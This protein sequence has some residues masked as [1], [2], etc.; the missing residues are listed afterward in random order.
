MLIYHCI[1]GMII[2]PAH[3]SLPSNL[4][5][6]SSMYILYIYYIQGS[7]KESVR[8]SF[9]NIR[10]DHSTSDTPKRVTKAGAS[11]Q[12]PS[13]RLRANATEI[14]MSEEDYKEAVSEIKGEWKKGKNHARL[15]NLME[16][17]FATRRKWI[18]EEHPLVTE[19]F[20]CLSSTKE[21]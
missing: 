15:K 2:P 9:K 18:A 12:P 6:Q 11:L 1:L 7:W 20:P 13:K 14:D 21:K 16:T 3:I 5:N 10:R 17:T 19:N 4:I 8:T